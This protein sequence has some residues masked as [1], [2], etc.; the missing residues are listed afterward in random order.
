MYRYL[1]AAPDLSITALYLSD[2]SI[3]GAMD[4]VFGRE[5][6]WDI[7]L[8]DGYEA[9]FV[10]GSTRRNEPRGFF[11]MLAPA[12][13]SEVRRG[14]FDALVV[15]GHTPAA[16]MLSVLAAKSAGLPVFTRCDTHLGLSRTPLKR[17]V[18]GAV[19]GSY[20]RRL[21]GA[22]AIGSA[23]RDFYRA[24]GVPESRI[25]LTPF[26]VDNARFGG[27][28]SISRDRRAEVRRKFGI[29]DEYPVVLFAGKFF[30]RKRPNDLLSAA[31]TYDSISPFHILLVGSGEMEAELNG[32]IKLLG[33]QRTHM[34][35]FANQDALPD[36]Y[37]AC[38]VFVL[39]STDEPWGLAVNEAMSAGLPVV[40]SDEVGC[41]RDL[42]QDG[43]NGAVFPAGNVGAL[44]EAL[45]P[46]IAD[47]D[48]RLRMGAASREIISRWSYAECLDGLRQALA[49]VNL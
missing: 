32:Q 36:I 9:R 37:G 28:A 43:V 30:R 1:N 34:A 47:T 15:H 21:A 40:V 38:D 8:L 11:S 25:F 3:R 4:E 24:M 33:I 46:I 19:M 35:G 13:W 29:E 48:V 14:G 39:P 6:K 16:V 10:A 42:V 27:G 18:R 26:A 31:A 22:L 5:V 20:Y 7:D 45:R 23:N 49:S 41:A 17:V 12:V 2:Y 44:A